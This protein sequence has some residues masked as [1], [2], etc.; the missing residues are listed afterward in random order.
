MSSRVSRVVSIRF[1]VALAVALAALQLGAGAQD[2]L[3]LMPGYDQFEKIA[4]ETQ[5]LADS[6][7]SLVVTWTPDSSAFASRVA[8]AL[9]PAAMTPNSRL[10]W[11]RSN[12]SSRK[13]QN[14]EIRN[15]FTTLMNT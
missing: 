6:F 3:K 13:L 15:R 11:P 7:G 1:G 14:T 5:G 12:S 8:P 2:R 4:R 10:V 9:P